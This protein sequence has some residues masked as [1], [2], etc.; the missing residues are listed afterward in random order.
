[1][2]RMRGICEPVMNAMRL[3]TICVGAQTRL[4]TPGLAVKQTRGTL[5][6]LAAL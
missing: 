1:M 3:G 6:L 5:P 4:R 2:D